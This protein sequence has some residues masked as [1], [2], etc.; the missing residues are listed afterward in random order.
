MNEV[1]H[2]SAGLALRLAKLVS[3]QWRSNMAPLSIAFDQSLRVLA[4]A[5]IWQTTMAFSFL[6]HSGGRTRWSI[7]RL[8]RSAPVSIASPALSGALL[9]RQMRLEGRGCSISVAGSG[10]ACPARPLN[11][12]CAGRFALVKWRAATAPLVPWLSADSARA[13]TLDWQPDIPLA[14][15]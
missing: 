12:V 14:K 1:F 4:G 8:R 2:R 15:P 5:G 7:H 6:I 13:A 10:K 9:L 11:A 3:E